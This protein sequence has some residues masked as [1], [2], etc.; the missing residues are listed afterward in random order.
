MTY[1]TVDIGKKGGKV[2]YTS[3]ATVPTFGWDLTKFSFSVVRSET[4]ACG[5]GSL[6][7]LALTA[8]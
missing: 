8:L 2:S 6:S 5:L 4:T 3:L 1:I 7:E